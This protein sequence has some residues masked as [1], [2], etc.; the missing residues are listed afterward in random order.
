M[1]NKYQVRSNW[2]RIVAIS[3]KLIYGRPAGDPKEVMCM[4]NP[5]LGVAIARRAVVESR[6]PYGS[7]KRKLFLEAVF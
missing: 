2:G 3:K 4:L 6:I 7:T 5:K 1:S